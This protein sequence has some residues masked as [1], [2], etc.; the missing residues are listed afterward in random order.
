M[1]KPVVVV[2]SDTC[3]QQSSNRALEEAG[4]GADSPIQREPVP[5][6]ELERGLV[7]WESLTDPMN[8]RYA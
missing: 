4:S 6:M 7:G 1:E 2:E 3:D 5:L 8:P